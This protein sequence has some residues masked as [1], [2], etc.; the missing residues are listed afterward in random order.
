[1]AGQSVEEIKQET[2]VYRNVFLA[3]GV[4]T[5]ITVAVSR[6]D[7]STGTAIAIALFIATIKGTLV[8]CYFM[9]LISE[10]KLVYSVLVLTA[11]FFVALIFLPLGSYFGSTGA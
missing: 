5:I 10:R 4:F 11:I 7:V 8:A 6:L 3:L 2:R 1:M 9:H